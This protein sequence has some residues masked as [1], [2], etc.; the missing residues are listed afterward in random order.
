M[1][2]F[3]AGS[4]WLFGR[5]WIALFGSAD[6][7]QCAAVKQEWLADGWAEDEAVL[8]YICIDQE[9]NYLL[10]KEIE[11]KLGYSGQFNAFPIA[12][13]GNQMAFG[14]EGFWKLAEALDEPDASLDELL[15]G[16]QAAV[17]AAEEPF[18]A[19]NAPADDALDAPSPSQPT[20]FADAPRLLYLSS[21]GCQ[22]CARQ[23]VELRLLKEKLPGLQVN[24]FEVTTDVGQ[25]MMRRVKEHFAI[26]ADDEQNLAPLVAWA[27]GYVTGE[28]ATAERLADALAALPRDAT[29]FWDTPVTDA[30]LQSQ[31]NANRTFLDKMR[32][33]TILLAGLGD[34]VNPCAFATVIFLVSYLLYLKRGKRFVL[35]AGLLFCVGVFASYLLFGIGLSFLMNYL[36]R[37]AIVK[38]LF[39]WAFALVGLVLAI[40]HLRDA[41]R[42]RRTG[43]VA[44]MEMGLNAQTHR[45]IHDRIHRWAE[46]SGWLMLPA[47]ILLGVVVS[48]ME[49]ACTGQIYLPTLAAI[50]SAGFN[51]HALTLLL[52]YNLAFILP[53]VAVTV[54]AY[55]GVGAKSLAAA[56]RDHVFATKIFMAIL[57]LLLGAVMAW[58]ALG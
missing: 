20:P 5:P 46:V 9:E 21:P 43:K 1:L 30:D 11:K 32:V 13:Q 31:Q 6:C 2:W 41:L 17:D 38:R 4:A 29:P 36:N 34:G 33:T 52:L 14:G 57:F 53:L 27:D 16:L 7:D 19:W 26:D 15:P 58:L 44:D 54:L 3:A 49:F 48:A 23:E 39:Y 42:F 50:N 56:A 45:K 24:H 12:L 22:K 40:L 37:A 25:V 8:A 55:F 35:A 10:L 47:T 18:V 28:L 51:L